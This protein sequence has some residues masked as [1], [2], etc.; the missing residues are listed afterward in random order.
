MI[1]H[2]SDCIFCKVAAGEIPTELLYTDEHCVAFRDIHPQAPTHILV[3][4]RRHVRDVPQLFEMQGDSSSGTLGG[5]LL[6]AANEVAKAAGLH[7][8]GFRLVINTGE[9]GGQSVPH[10]HVHVLGKR[11]MTWPPG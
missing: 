2:M 10:L 11:S 7:E 4:P 5:R 6:K 8:K 1:R 3:V 9:Q